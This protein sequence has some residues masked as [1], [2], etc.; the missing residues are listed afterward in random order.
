MRILSKLSKT[1][2]NNKKFSK[3]IYK[4]YKNFEKIVKTFWKKFW[5]FW[6]KLETFKRNLSKI[7]K[8]VTC[9]NYRGFIK[10]GE[11]SRIVREIL[12]VLRRILGIILKKL[13][14]CS[15][16]ILKEIF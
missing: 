4:S 9:E 14:Q 13:W 1:R 7:W 11:I 6:I 15:L 16:K 2:G 5:K 8:Y 10:P 12:K 3:I